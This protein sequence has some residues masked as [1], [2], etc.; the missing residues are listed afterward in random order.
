MT[1]IAPVTTQVRTPPM[2]TGDVRAVRGQRAGGAAAVYLAVALLLAIPYF[3]LVVDYPSAKSSADQ[4]V[5]IVEYYPSM[6]AM[7]LATYV[8]FGIAVG[9]L[10]LALW[11]RLRAEAP[12]TVRVAT[13]FG[14]SWSFTLVA[15]GMIFAH[16]ITAVEGL[17]ATDHERA[18]LTWQAV[19]P[20]ALGLGGAG[21][22]V[23]GGP[24]VLL[25]SLVALRG[26][27][28]PKPLAWLGVVIGAVGFASVVPPVREAA[29]V[30]GL[31]QIPWFVW[32]GVVLMKN[33]PRPS[34]PTH[35]RA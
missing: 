21:G 30:F 33:D 15:S 1:T 10:A 32:L 2:N 6:Y 25:V 18:V 28:L 17:A 31:L 34:G 24:W 35:P 3:L 22:E 12:S 26:G 16:G 14:L 9:V 8:F 29:M 7:Y 27:A 4:V 20:I 19:E 5:L 23:L 11:D 13:L